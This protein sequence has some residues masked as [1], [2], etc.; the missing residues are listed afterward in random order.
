MFSRDLYCRHPKKQGLIWE[1]VKI[2]TDARTT[3]RASSRLITTFMPLKHSS[4]GNDGTILFE[5]YGQNWAMKLIEVQNAHLTKADIMIVIAAELIF[6]LTA[7]HC[8]V[9]GYFGM[10]PVAQNG[11]CTEDRL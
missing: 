5:N 7:V 1:T 4:K 11:Y 9:N 3:N 2:Y 10:Q 8:F 6:S